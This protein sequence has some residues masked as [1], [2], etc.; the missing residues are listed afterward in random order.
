M[1]ITTAPTATSTKVRFVFKDRT[2]TPEQLLEQIERNPK[3]VSARIQEGLR[4]EADPAVLD[5]LQTTALAPYVED[6][7]EVVASAVG[8]AVVVGA[9]LAGLAIGLAVG[10]AL[11]LRRRR[12]RRADHG[13]VRQR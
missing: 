9:F 3:Q 1:T 7:G 4:M 8:A 6:D 11:G 2:L 13:L 12:H 5:A 10:Y